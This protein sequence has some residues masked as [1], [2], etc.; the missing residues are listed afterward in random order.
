MMTIKC[1]IALLVTATLLSGG[2][3]ISAMAG[4]LKVSVDVGTSAKVTITDFGKTLDDPL[5]TRAP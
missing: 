5:V 4:L 2:N 1:K 3:P